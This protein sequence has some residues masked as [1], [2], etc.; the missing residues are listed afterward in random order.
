MKEYRLLLKCMRLWK[1]FV[2]RSKKRKVEAEQA[3]ENWAI[4]IHFHE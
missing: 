3:L 1:R 2:E 4:S